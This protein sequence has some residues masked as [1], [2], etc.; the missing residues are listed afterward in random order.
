MATTTVLT[1]INTD[2]FPI[3]SRH[4]QPN[5]ELVLPRSKAGV[6]LAS[7]TVLQRVLTDNH[8]RWHIFFNLKRFH[9][10]TAHAALTLWFLGADPAVLEGSYEEHIKIQRPAFKSPGPITR[11]T[12]KD[13]LGDDTYYQ[14]YLGF[15]Q[16]ELKEK[17]FGPLL[18]EYVFGHSANAV[19]S[20]VTK[21]HPEMLKRFLAGLL[22]PMIHTGFGVEF[23]LP[24]TFAEGLAQTAVH[25]ADKGDLI[26]LKWFAPPD[27]GLIYKFTGIRISAKEQKDVHA[28]SIL[29]RI[30]EDPELGGFPA[31]AF[32][33]QF[34]PSVVQRYGTA[35]A[36]YVDDWTLEG[37][38]E[39]KVQELLWT[40]A[41]LYGVAGVEANGGFV[42]DFFLMHLVTSSLFLSEVFSELKRSSQVELLRGYFATCL[43]WYIGRGRPKLDIAEFFSRDN[44]RPTAP[45]PQPTPHEGANPSPSAP[46]AITPNP[47][48]PVL[49]STLAHPDDHLAKLQ[50]SLSEYSMHFGLT[51]AGTFKNTELK[52][53][54]L[55]DGTLFIRAAGLSLS[56]MGWVREGQAPGAWS[57]D[58][59]FQPAESKL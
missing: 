32:E 54:G 3:P 14:A 20:S 35:I 46:E 55:I 39:K 6:S 10:H 16:D 19:A 52:D 5:R 47:W 4:V 37:D 49:Q 43:A 34:Y 56:A 9:N 26:P 17:S 42:A 41:L 31:P 58:G 21:E 53:A 38:L 13:H 27:T 8:K 24:G 28:F 33:E 15:F 2:L 22:H 45:G 25:L 48:L 1:D 23:S 29:A 36:K 59:F 51:P 7:T 44:A 57:F 11:H 50:R 30:L 40:N 12:W 18:E